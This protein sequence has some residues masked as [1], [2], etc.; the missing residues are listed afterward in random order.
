MKK[1]FSLFFV[2]ILTLVGF[3]ACSGDTGVNDPELA[4]T[5]ELPQSGTD[6]LRVLIDFPSSRPHT[7]STRNKTLEKFK[8]EIISAGGPNDITFDCIYYDYQYGNNGSNYGI[9]E[10]D[11]TR[12]R[13]EI[14]AGKGP[15]VFITVCDP[16]YE[17]PVFKYPDQMMSRRVFL[18]LDDYIEKAKFMEWDKLTPIVMEAGKTDEGQMVLPLT[19]SM[20]LTVFRKEELEHTPSQTLTFFDIAE[21]SN[22]AS[23]FS[24]ERTTEFGE[25][26]MDGDRLAAVFSE[27]VNYDTETLAF[28]EE[29]IKEIILVLGDLESRRA[30]G[31]YDDILSYYHTNLMVG[32]NSYPDDEMYNA[33]F[34]GIEGKESLPLFPLYSTQG[35]Y[36]ATITSFAA[37]N[38]N[39]KRPDDAFFVL[40]YLLSLECQ[41]SPLY[42]NLTY[43]QAIPTHEDAMQRR[44]EVVSEGVSYN[45]GYPTWYL[46]RS[47]FDELCALREN[48]SYVRFRTELDEKLVS[49][50]AISKYS[51][52][53]GESLNREVHNAYMEMQMMLAES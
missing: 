29:D 15:D 21:S 43:N 2:L 26:T 7:Q 35:G 52:S 34:A 38:R 45:Y 50:L 36:C 22:P 37:I 20:P 6:S 24:P 40:D 49:L 18:P 5:G 33:M 53:S 30:K 46:G 19:Y 41:C 39:T 9:R 23:L 12:I 32:F 3:T 17:D 14:M 31:E 8:K 28:S 48:I 44:T 1:Y 11:L 25:Y 42:A 13:T 51:P 10:G 27:L 47:N 16:E 4:S